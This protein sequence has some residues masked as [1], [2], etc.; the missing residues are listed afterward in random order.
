VAAEGE[1]VNAARAAAL[2]A[3]GIQLVAWLIYFVLRCRRP[4]P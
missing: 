4:S 3:L 2:L 1:R